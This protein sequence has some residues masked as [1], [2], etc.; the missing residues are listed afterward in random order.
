[1][2]FFPIKRRLFAEFQRGV[3]RAKVYLIE[4]SAEREIVLHLYAIKKYGVARQF[5]AIRYSDIPTVQQLVGDADRRIK[6]LMRP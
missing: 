3:V 2:M 4:H 6:D 1:M 5:A